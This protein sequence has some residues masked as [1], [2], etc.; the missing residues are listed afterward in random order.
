MCLLKL[1]WYFLYLCW[2]EPNLAHLGRIES[3]QQFCLLTASG[4]HR[5]PLGDRS[6]FSDGLQ[7]PLA[8]HVYRSRIRALLCRMTLYAGT[9]FADN[10]V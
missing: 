7:Y 8:K 5:I 9:L 10:V 4:K 6:A 1:L 2:D 3:A